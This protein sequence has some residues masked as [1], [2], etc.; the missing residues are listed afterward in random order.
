MFHI[1]V[2]SRQPVYEQIIEQLESLVL[3]GVMK[4]GEQIP[5]V[6]SLSVQLSINPNTIQ[7]AYSELDR[8]GILYSVPGRGCFI[9]DNAQ[10]LLAEIRRK[11]IAK[12]EELVRG[13]ALAGIG[14]QEVFD[15]VEQAYR[16]PAQADGAA[17]PHSTQ[18]N[19]ERREDA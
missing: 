12:L 10:A 18:T 9:S 14:K 13:L 16:T 4:P 5:P 17:S 2:M 8:R 19:E 15:A 3:T 1:D 11:D 7:K 6:R